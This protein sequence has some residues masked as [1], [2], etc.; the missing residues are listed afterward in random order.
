[1][2]SHRRPPPGACRY[3]DFAEYR[4][5][6][7]VNPSILKPLTLNVT[8]LIKTAEEAA[9]AAGTAGGAGKA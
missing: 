3:I 5:M 4:A 9:A 6:C 7:T 8:D 2:A 1:V